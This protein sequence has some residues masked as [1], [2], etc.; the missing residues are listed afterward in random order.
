MVFATIGGGPLLA[1]RLHAPGCAL[2]LLIGIAGMQLRL[3]CN[4]LDGMVAIEGGMKGKA[5]DL[6]NERR[7]GTLI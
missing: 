7:T 6:F 4:L 1:C 3:L 5:G 2:L